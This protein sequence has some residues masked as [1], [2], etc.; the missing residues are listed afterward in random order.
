PRGGGI[1]C[2]ALQA[3]GAVFADGQ[4]RAAADHGPEDPPQRAEHRL[5][6]GLEHRPVLQAEEHGS[7]R[8]SGVAQRERE[9][10]GLRAVG[11]F[12]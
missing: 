9:R 7:R 12:L 4:N 10:S 8:H 1:L 3:R 2:G 11:A 5:D 6:P